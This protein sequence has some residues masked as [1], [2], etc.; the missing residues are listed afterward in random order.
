V[1]LVA[2]FLWTYLAEQRR[3]GWSSLWMLLIPLGP[4]LWLADLALTV[5]DPLAPF[6]AANRFWGHAVTWPWETIGAA[7]VLAVQA[8]AENSLVWINLITTLAGLAAC[9]WTLAGNGPRAWGAWGLVLLTLYLCLP[10]EEPL[11]SF[12]RYSLPVLPLWL[13]LARRCRPPLLEPL[14]VGLMAAVQ[15][16]LAVLFV[17][18]YWVG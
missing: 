4:A 3:L 17:H 14:L 7:V 13:L 10:A 16:L 9:V 1:L 11:K 18:G 8:P 5:G 15:G 2:P 12:L 6:E